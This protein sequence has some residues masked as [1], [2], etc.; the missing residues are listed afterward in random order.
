[1]SA[2]TVDQVNS[3][4][5]DANKYVAQQHFAISMVQPNTFGFT[6]PWFKDISGNSAPRPP[7]PATCP[8]SAAVLDRPECEEKHRAL[9]LSINS[10]SGVRLQTGALLF[11]QLTLIVFVLRY[12]QSPFRQPFTIM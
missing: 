2:T 8:L 7:V 11:Y 6:Q 1:M 5:I 10:C 3:I 12:F 9:I 4:V